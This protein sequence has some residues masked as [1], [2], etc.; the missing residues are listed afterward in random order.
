MG[1]MHMKRFCQLILFAAV[2]FLLT[3]QSPFAKEKGTNRP[4]SGSFVGTATFDLSADNGCPQGYAKV[5]T[6]ALGNLSHLG[7]TALRSS[8]CASPPRSGLPY[9]DEQV[10]LIAA[11]GDEVWATY[12]AEDGKTSFMPMYLNDGTG[13]FINATGTADF[14]CLVQPVRDVNGKMDF[15]VP[16][17]WMATIEGEISY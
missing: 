4:L 3:A 17:P 10:T 12:D 1:G 15:S 5:T 16:W 7:Q 6:L 2:L 8:H 13:R 14:N 9:L 11:N